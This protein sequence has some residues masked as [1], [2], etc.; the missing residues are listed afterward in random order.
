MLA[1]EVTAKLD[2][3]ITISSGVV[4]GSLISVHYGQPAPTGYTLY[5]SGNPKNISWEKL[6]E[7]SSDL[8]V[9]LSV[10]STIQNEIFITRGHPP[11]NQISRFNPA[12][13]HVVSNYAM[14]TARWISSTVNFNNKFYVI[15]GNDGNNNLSSVE[16]YNPNTNQ[17]S[18]GPALPTADRGGA[19]IVFNNELYYFSGIAGT[20]IYKLD[21]QSNLSLIHI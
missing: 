18:F 20:G 2:Q 15:G 7:A 10:S 11:S 8:N 4:A 12:S 19:S 21:E 16:I 5:E 1:P 6:R 13:N 9:S 3:N 17:W 14:Q